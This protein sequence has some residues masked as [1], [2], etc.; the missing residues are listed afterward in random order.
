MAELNIAPMTDTGTRDPRLAAEEVLETARTM[1]RSGN[2][3][4]AVGTLDHH[5]RSGLWRWAR[6]W[7]ELVSLMDEPADYGRLRALW[8]AAPRRVHSSLPIQRAVARAASAGREHDEARAL[9]RKT[10]ITQARR[11]RHPRA[12]LGQA[13][14]RVLSALPARASAP[15]S[16]RDEAFDLRAVVALAALS[17]ELDQIGVKPFLISG[18]LLGYLREGNFISW[19]KD[20]DVGIFTSEIKTGD[21]ESAFDRSA[22]FTVRRLDFNAER[23]R[24]D[25]ANGIKVDIF[26]HYGTADGKVWHD[27]T[28]TRWW[29]SPFELKEIEFLGERQYVP[30]DPERYLDENYG[31]WRVPEPN[32]DARI[33]APNVEITDQDYFDTLL[34]FSLLDAVVKGNSVKRERYRGMLRELG[35]GEWL[36]EV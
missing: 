11:R 12:R 16:V 19:D 14:R 5:L 17:S 36:N 18:T 4:D 27:G 21:V 23:L 3:R 30:S 32:F 29:N 8:L 33:D 28:A 31:N 26:P 10:I 22:E 1:V 34:Y 7:K 2:R 25:H 15:A 9:L 13:K 6:L 24:V 35:E 20:I